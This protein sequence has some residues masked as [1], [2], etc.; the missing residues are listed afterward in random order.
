[1]GH[2]AR[3]MYD[4]FDIVRIF[5]FNGL[6]QSSSSSCQLPMINGRVK[7][8]RVFSLAK[9]GTFSVMHAADPDDTHIC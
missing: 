5:I 8:L 3:E 7:V 6:Q 9:A 4:V 1:V 2:E